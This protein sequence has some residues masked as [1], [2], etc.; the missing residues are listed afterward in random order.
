[1]WTRSAVTGIDLDSNPLLQPTLVTKFICT[2]QRCSVGR[3]YT[4]AEKR[5]V[6]TCSGLGLFLRSQF[7]ENNCEDIGL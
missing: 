7:N 2:H 3:K 5:Q 1:M 4:S 6:T